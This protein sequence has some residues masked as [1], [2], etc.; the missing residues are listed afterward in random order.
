[1]TGY[2]IKSGKIKFILQSHLND[3]IKQMVYQI[4]ADLVLY[5]P[6]H[7]ISPIHGI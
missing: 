2:N 6:I 4:E 7:G 5:T 3:F 1:M